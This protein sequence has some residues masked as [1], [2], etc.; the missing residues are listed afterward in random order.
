MRS[1]HNGTTGKPWLIVSNAQPLSK[2]TKHRHFKSNNSINRFICPSNTDGWNSYDSIALRVSR[3]SWHS[4]K[5]KPIDSIIF[6]HSQR[7]QVHWRIID[8]STLS[9]L[10][11]TFRTLHCHNRFWRNFVN[12]NGHFLYTQVG[13]WTCDR[14]FN[15]AKLRKFVVWQFRVRNVG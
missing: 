9:T 14:Q 6:H 3:I 2:L 7:Q 12:P 5:L 11:P 8:I 15:F 1:L 10:D 13:N 4:S